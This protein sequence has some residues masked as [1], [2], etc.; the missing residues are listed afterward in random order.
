MC[1]PPPCEGHLQCPRFRSLLPPPTRCVFP[2]LTHCS[3]EDVLG[4]DG[5]GGGTAFLG[6]VVGADAVDADAD[7]D[8]A[9]A[10]GGSWLAGG[11]AAGVG[12]ADPALFDLP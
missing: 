9:D 5:G 3:S 6:T 11:C 7:A 10:G 4:P 1:R 12:V 8:V 2:T